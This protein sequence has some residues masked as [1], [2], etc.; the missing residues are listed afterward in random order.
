MLT[1]FFAT[2]A[3]GRIGIAM[4]NVALLWFVHHRTGSFGA[5][6]ALSAGLAV[7][8]ALVGPQTARIVDRFGQ[9]LVL[10][11]LAV[12]HATA[13]VVVLGTVGPGSGRCVLVALGC[14][15]G[16]TLPQLGVFSAAR[17]AHR[18]PPGPQLSRA[19]GWE[20]SANSAAFLLGPAA[21]VSWA[22]SGHA[23]TAV[24]VAGSLAVGAALLLG[25]QRGSAP[26]GQRPHGPRA[27]VLPRGVGLPIAVNVAIGVHFGAMPVAMAAV[28]QGTGAATWLI[29]ASSGGGLLAGSGFAALRWRAPVRRQL[30][31]TATVFAALALLLVV[32]W[33]LPALVVVLFVV[34]AAVPPVLVTTSLLARDR[35]P[36]G[37]LTSTFSWLASCSA[38]G[39]A[40]GAAGAGGVVDAV[41][42]LGAFALAG[43]GA[44]GV[45]V[46]ERILR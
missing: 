23:R 19:F 13:V 7:A 12:L 8:E 37:R 3:A 26:P 35:A 32:P 46:L 36:V 1:A 18:Y 34:G 33:P 30:R 44:V 27:T 9:P 41:G 14:A 43:A 28:S 39:G 4:T 40:A 24:L 20:S 22:A 5:A 38:A 2:A 31:V 29:V 17:W 42:P 21:A 6:G 45:T 10:T 15:V 16:A 11:I 25:L